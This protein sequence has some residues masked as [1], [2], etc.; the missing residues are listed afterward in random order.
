M[1]DV[2]YLCDGICVLTIG[3][4]IIEPVYDTCYSL[5]KGVIALQN[6]EGAIL[7]WDEL[8]K[9]TELKAIYKGQ[10]T[11]AVGN[12]GNHYFL[13]TPVDDPL[14]AGGDPAFDAPNFTPIDPCDGFEYV[15]G[16]LFAVKNVDG[17]K[18][19]GGVGTAIKDWITSFTRLDN[20]M[21]EVSFQSGKVCSNVNIAESFSYTEFVPA[22]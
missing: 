20:G 13:Q 10:Y 17:Q 2:I 11:V 21:Y 22:E 19:Y 6:S 3:G 14:V 12:D 8:M 7:V 5:D 9:Y 15:D 18:L 4:I 16:Q 1:T